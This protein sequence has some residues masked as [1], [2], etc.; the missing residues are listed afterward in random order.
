MLLV[1]MLLLI[2]PLLLILGA[3]LCRELRI[4]VLILMP[5]L[6]RYTNSSLRHSGRAE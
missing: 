2:R 3:R 1:L 5:P 6:P 4:V